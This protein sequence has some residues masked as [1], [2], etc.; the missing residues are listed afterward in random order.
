MKEI[1][2]KNNTWNIRCLVGKMIVPS[3]QRIILKIVGFLLRV[4]MTVKR[5]NS[6]FAEELFNIGVDKVLVAL[7]K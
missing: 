7:E 6:N 5:I 4:I 1:I 2:K 3:T